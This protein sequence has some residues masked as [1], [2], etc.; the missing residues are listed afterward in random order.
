MLK[1][2]KFH[3]FPNAHF[4]E[5]ARTRKDEMTKWSKKAAKHHKKV[6]TT[7]R[8]THTRTKRVNERE[9]KKTK[10]NLYHKQIIVH[11]SLIT[12]FLRYRSTLF[13]A[14]AVARSQPSCVSF[15]LRSM[16]LLFFTSVRVF[17]FCFFH[18]FKS[19]AVRQAFEYY[20]CAQ[21]TDVYNREQ[22]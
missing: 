11:S 7:H 10:L 9:R 16:E 12:A 1:V 4:C 22:Q 3:C 13:S 5:R 8:H 15:H 14:S 19:Y 18:F 17:P 21:A 6:T 2:F 20:K